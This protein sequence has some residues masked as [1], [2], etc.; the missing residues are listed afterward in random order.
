MWN[1]DVE[2]ENGVVLKVWKLVG[3]QLDCVNNKIIVNIEGYV[4]QDKDAVININ[5]PVSPAEG[6]LYSNVLAYLEA[7]AQ[8][9]QK[10]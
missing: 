3:A 9:A 4:D 2:L 5:L 7:A 10:E 6:D 1:K 8:A